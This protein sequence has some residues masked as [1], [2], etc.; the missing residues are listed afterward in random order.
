MLRQLPS[1]LLPTLLVGLLVAGL[2]VHGW[3]GAI[4]LGCVAVVLTWLAALS[5]PGLNA[6]GRLL[7]V[8]AIACVLLG[9]V[10]RVTHL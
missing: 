5:W 10:L 2:A 3:V 9:A 4:A 6:Q 8:T 7:R 1:W